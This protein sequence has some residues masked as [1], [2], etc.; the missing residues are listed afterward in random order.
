MRELLDELDSRGVV[1]GVASSSSPARLELALRLVG[2]WDYFAPYIFSASMV[3][4]GKPAPDLFLFAARALGSDPAVCAV[5]EDSIPGI[6]AA[7][8][9][10]MTP[11]GFCAGSHCSLT[12]AERLL[13]AGAEHVC[14]DAASLASLFT[15]SANL[16]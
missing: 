6:R 11:I 15:Q 9:A 16:R 5:I 12:H 13:N 7:R 4:R 1:R 8:A 14:A 2:F 3:S 10:G